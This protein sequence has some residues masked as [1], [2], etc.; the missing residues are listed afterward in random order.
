M[1]TIDTDVCIVG[2]GFAGLTAARRLTEAGRDVV[3]LEA[4]DRVGGR[5]WTRH[6]ADG[7]PL[8]MG[9]TFIGPHQ[10]RVRALVEEVG[11]KLFQTNVQGDSILANGG[12][13]RR[14]PADK[15]PRVNPV[16]LASFGQALYRIDR[17]AKTIPL[18]AP[19]EAK[20]A[21]EWD[22]QSLRA[23]MSKRNV[24]TREG[25]EMLEA[26]FRALFASDLSEV[27]LLNGLFLLQS[28]GGL[29]NFMSIEGGYQDAQ[30]VGGVGSV[31]GTVAADLGDRVHLDTPVRDIELVGA[32][33]EVRSPT[34]TVVR[35]RKVVVALPPGLAGHIRY[36]PA[37]PGDKALLFHQVP[38]GTELKAVVV[39]DEPFWTADGLCGASVCVGDSYEAVSY[40]H[41]TLP[42]IL[43]V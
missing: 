40:T 16:A 41:L 36:A 26:T 29:L 43:R 27:S 10:D 37:L 35:A 13:N 22:A 9:A 32:G 12:K 38:G 28:G 30:V 6:D 2:A 3:V 39:Y 14:Y 23:W 19:W 17:M 8:D 21:A 5:V 7:T 1:A 42:T 25:R 34:G 24:P 31:V 33:Y 11:G 4:R 15:T 20:K 18:E